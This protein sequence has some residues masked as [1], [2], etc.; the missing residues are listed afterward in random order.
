[1]RYTILVTIALLLSSCVEKIVYLPFPTTFQV[2]LNISVQNNNAFFVE[3]SVSGLEIASEIRN[4]LQ[5]EFGF[6]E[7]N[8]TQIEGLAFTILE[9]DDI[10]SAINASFSLSYA[11]SPQETLFD[12][13]EL[14]LGNRIGERQEA[15]LNA[16][17]VSLLN[18]ALMDII[19]GNN[20]SLVI[21]NGTGEAFPEVNQFT[22]L[23]EFT[24][25]PIIEQKVEIFDPF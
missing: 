8:D 13:Q 11:G 6:D 9:T 20:N 21:V 17:G 7:I 3:E 2:I 14:I 25:T 18:Q 16:N 12:L 23:L 24:A 1:M 19:D 10:H 15:D 5:G 4:Q 22:L